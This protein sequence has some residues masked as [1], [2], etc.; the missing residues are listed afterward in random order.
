MNR[1]L[2]V[3]LVLGGAMAATSALTNALVPSQKV[4]QVHASFSLDAM[5]PAQFGEW[6]I[7]PAIVPL[8]P[9]PEQQGMLAKIYDQT[10]SRTYVNREGQ[11]VMLSIAYGGDQSK[12]GSGKALARNPCHGLL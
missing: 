8:A 12:A 11:R 1:R 7:D 2:A 3:S 4:V 5:V 9:N 6:R 10:L